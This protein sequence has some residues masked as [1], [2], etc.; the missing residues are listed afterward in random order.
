MMLPT[1]RFHHLH[2]RATD[3]S[4]A[5][6]FYTRQ[7]PSATSGSWGGFDALL[8]PNEVMI[9][10]DKVDAPPTSTPQSAIW[11][12]GWHVTDCRASVATFDSRTEV[13]TQPLYT[14]AEGGSVSLSSDTWFRSGDLL[15]VTQAQI[16]ELR[17]AATPPPGGPGFAYFK[18]PDDAL[19][20]IAG[21]YSQ[22]RF[23]H[24]HMWQEDPLCAQLWYQKHLNAPSRAS[25]G[26]V[27]VTESDCKV[28]R[29]TERT[30]PALNP[31]GMYRAPRGGVT[32]GDVDVIWYPNQGESPLGSSAG[33]LQD[34]LAL[35][36]ADLG[37]W[38]AKLRGEGVSFVSDIYPL[39]DTRAMMVEGPSRE[40]IEL[41]EVH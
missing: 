10:F 17:A 40:V 11:H 35:S 26:D 31:Q 5:I 41:V 21:D 1:P 13:K 19:F 33:Q 15:G 38:I 36:V 6:D 29:A 34:H 12:F 3:P 4:A 39:G 7:F 9:L 16:A 30:F 32:F 2:M 27:A 37:A 24:I 20:E 18:G 22:E 25:F 23:N 8:S 28:A 14:G